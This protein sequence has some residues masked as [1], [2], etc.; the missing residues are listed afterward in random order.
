VALGF[1]GSIRTRWDVRGVLMFVT[2]CKSTDIGA[3]YAGKLIGGP[4][5]APHVS[6]KKTW[7]GA[8]G[9][10]ALATA[11]AL[12]WGLAGLLPWLSVPHAVLYGALTGTVAILG[13]LAESLLKREAGVKDSGALLPGA[14]G[15]LDMVDDV[16]FCA[17]FTYLF[18][19]F[20]Y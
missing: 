3:Y 8:I 9:G 15:M 12:T 2:V 4:R 11:V 20:T 5:L 13:D 6:P 10:T 19:C 18:F 7:A 1:I 16:L 14:G 17:P